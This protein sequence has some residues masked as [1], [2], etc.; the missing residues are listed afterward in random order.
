MSL[1]KRA[2][3]ILM[4]TYWSSAGWRPDRSVA[5]EDFAYAR[6]KGV[7]FDAVRLSHDD[8]I[9]AAVEAA[10]NVRQTEIVAA[11]IASLGSRRL[12][13]RSALGSYAVA[14]HLG[15]HSLSV[16]DGQR[17]C[18]CCGLYGSQNI[19]LNVLNFE[20]L[21]WGG[22][23][24]LD[25]IFMSFDL[26]TFRDDIQPSPEAADFIIL[27]DIL[28]AARGLPE[29]ARL[30]DLD[31]ALAKSLRSNSAERRALIS[32]LGFAGILVDPQRPSFRQRFVPESEREQT[33]WHKDDWPYPVQWWNG[34]CGVDEDAVL[35]WF[36]M[37][38]LH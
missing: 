9:K 19:D 1:D 36:P 17:R 7:M 8:A 25:P 38:T 14:R 16:L 22:V 28:D 29:T 23:R 13:W 2:V 27:R 20:R 33:P 24:H 26:R 10:A 37:L 5:P 34:R 30:G 3:A 21:K 11:F 31:K 4:N 35:D 18:T 32:I 6:S 12:D 15:Q